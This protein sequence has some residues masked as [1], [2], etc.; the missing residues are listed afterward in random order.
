MVFVWTNKIEYLPTI[1]F[2][3]MKYKEHSFVH[4]WQNL[5]ES[6]NCDEIGVGQL[7]KENLY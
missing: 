7:E 4:T 5:I 2:P 3:L 1:H 6:T